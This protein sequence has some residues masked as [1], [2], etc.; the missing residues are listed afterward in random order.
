MEITFYNTKDAPNVVN[1]SL[2]LIKGFNNL[3]LKQDMD[4]LNPEFF[5][6]FNTDY[7]D[8]I[9]YMYIAETKRYYFVRCELTTGQR[10]RVVGK[11]DVLMSWKEDIRKQGECVVIRN[12]M[13]KSPYVVDAET[14]LSTKSVYAIKKFPYTFNT[15]SVFLLA[16]GGE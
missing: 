8:N 11:V 6:M 12:T 15:Y 9:N 2:T 5:M 10:V 3:P 7:V 1:K 16:A 4:I 14:T 13:L